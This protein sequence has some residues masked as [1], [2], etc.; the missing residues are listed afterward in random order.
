MNLIEMYAMMPR[1]DA[2]GLFDASRIEKAS[3][4]LQERSKQTIELLHRYLEVPEE[5]TTSER[6]TS[7]ARV[8]ATS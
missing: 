5:A 3:E 1:D 6:D 7:T 4:M 2:P 8:P